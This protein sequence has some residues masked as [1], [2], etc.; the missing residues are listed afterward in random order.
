MIEWGLRLKQLLRP[1][2]D[3]KR[4]QSCGQ[5]VGGLGEAVGVFGVHRAFLAGADKLSAV[6]LQPPFAAVRPVGN[7][8]WM[9]VEVFHG[10]EELLAGDGLHGVVVD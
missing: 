5:V 1:W 6:V 7:D 8:A 2:R 4:G 9:D 10:D 3:R